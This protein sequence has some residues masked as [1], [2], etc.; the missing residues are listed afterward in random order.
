M[1]GSGFLFVFLFKF[2]FWVLGWVWFLASFKAGAGFSFCW[3]RVLG[4]SLGRLSG[5]TPLAAY[6]TGMP[7]YGIS[8][9]IVI[10]TVIFAVSDFMKC[11]YVYQSDAQ[12]NPIVSSL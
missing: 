1:A 4:N 10:E 6:C 11:G 12:R 7:S 5:P 8:V 2:G 9:R 3:G